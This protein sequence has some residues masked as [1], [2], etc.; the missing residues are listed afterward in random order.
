MIVHARDIIGKSSDRYFSGNGD[1]NKSIPKQRILYFQGTITVIGQGKKR[2]E[3]DLKQFAQY[4]VRLSN[5][6]EGG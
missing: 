6:I 3:I 2:A 1:T 5:E 4:C